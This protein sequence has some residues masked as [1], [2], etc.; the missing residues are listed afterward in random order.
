MSRAGIAAAV[1]LS[2]TALAMPATASGAPPAGTLAI[3]APVG[4]PGH[5]DTSLLL[6]GGDVLVSTNRGA[7]GATGPSKLF[8]YDQR[9]RLKR[10]YTITGQDLGG[11]HGTMSMAL[12]ARGRV[13]VADYA[14]PRILRIDMTSGRQTTYATVPDLKGAADNGVGDSKPWPDGVA[15][16]PDGRL[17]VTDL[18]QGTVFVVP[19]GGGAARAWLQDPVLRSTFGPN[20][21][22]LT[23]QGDALLDVTAST[24]PATAGRGTLYRFAIVA[25]K[26]GP[27][28]LVY[29]TRPGEGPDGFALGRSGRLYVPTL[30]TD[31][32]AVVGPGGTEV[33]SYGGAGS[34]LDSPSSVTLLDS[35]DALVTNLTYFTNDASHDLVLR[36]RLND[37]P[38]PAVRPD[39]PG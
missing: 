21:L 19:R 13:Y 15:F 39:V 22:V 36:L 11:D 9:G 35:G 1:V 4:R 33:A 6:P 7:H 5:A 24:V 26:P 16:L 29:A 8:R 23:P 31:R 37:L 20:Q 18:A 27:L 10:T 38:V 12:D 2:L 25:G 14:P 17:L 32:V 34:L 30:V 3:F 28:S